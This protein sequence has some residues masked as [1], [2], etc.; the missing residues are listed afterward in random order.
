MARG[1]SGVRLRGLDVVTEGKRT[2]ASQV[3][4]DLD[5]D[6]KLSPSD[7]QL[8]E[9]EELLLPGR[10]LMEGGEAAKWRQGVGVGRQDLQM[11]PEPREYAYLVT[12]LS[13]EP[14]SVRAA[15]GIYLS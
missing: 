8:T 11:V 6:G 13:T 7:R 9:L 14:L 1:Q 15:C 5:F 4:R 2:A 3:W 12:G 10:A